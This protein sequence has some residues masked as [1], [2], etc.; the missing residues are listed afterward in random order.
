MSYSSSNHS[1][2]RSVKFRDLEDGAGDASGSR[3]SKMSAALSFDASVGLLSDA[4]ASMLKR[5]TIYLLDEPTTGLDNAVARSLQK[6]LD[7]LAEN[8]TT[9]CITHHLG[10]LKTSDDVIY[11]DAGHIV[12]HGSFDELMKAKGTFYQQVNARGDE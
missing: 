12:E 8:A 4:S 2:G 1:S 6:T 3:T 5:G 9:I 10:D 11:L 7:K